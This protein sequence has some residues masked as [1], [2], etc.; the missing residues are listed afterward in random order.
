MN[1]K[2]DSTDLIIVSN[3]GITRWAPL[4]VV[5]GVVGGF[6]ALSY[7][8]YHA[9]IQSVKEEDLVVVEADK[10]P[11]KE[12]PA[13]PGGM[14]FPNQD[15]TVFETFASNKQPAK[16]ERVLPTP[17]E[18]MPKEADS[19]ETTTWVNKA[20]PKQGKEQ[21]I[22][23]ETPKKPDGKIT[24]TDS[25]ATFDGEKT[26]AGGHQVI[27]AQVPADEE[28]TATYVAPKKSKDG[29]KLELPIKAV[30]KPFTPQK[31]VTAIMSTSSDEASGDLPVKESPK[32]EPKPAPKPEK[33]TE[34]APK[35]PKTDKKPSETHVSASGGAFAVQLGAYR[36]QAEAEEQ[37]VKMHLKQKELSDKKPMIVKADL[38]SKGVYY[39][40]RVSGLASAS[41][42]RTLCHALSS[43]GQACILPTGN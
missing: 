3:S 27:A 17:E 7:Y 22:G 21:V 11:I 15:K 35:K 29:Q 25:K 20:L 1:D 39:R 6:V 41:D 2:S 26:E 34:K 36:S 19:S 43:K 16:V 42:A 5:L 9:G 8:A 28:Q 10:T 14:Q 33:V 23:K 30:D 32:V 31:T 4:V 18:P 38:G 13:D 24:V 12:K 37:W 40:L